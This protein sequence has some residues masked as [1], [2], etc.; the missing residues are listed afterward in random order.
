VLGFSEVW[1]FEADTY[2]ELHEDQLA[3][4]QRL[5]GWKLVGDPGEDEMQV[6]WKPTPTAL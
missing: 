1:E 3:V 2:T 6:F 5:M 4:I